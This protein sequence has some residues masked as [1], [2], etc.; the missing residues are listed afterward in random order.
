MIGITI[1][2]FG[3]FF[4]RNLI[5]G[6]EAEAKEIEKGINEALWDIEQSGY[7]NDIGPMAPE[8]LKQ[9][10]NERLSSII[11]GMVQFAQT[12]RPGGGG[13]TF[14]AW[15]RIGG[16]TSDF[17]YH[18]TRGYAIGT[19]LVK[20]DHSETDEKYKNEYERIYAIFN[21]SNKTIPDQALR[22]KI[23]D[24]SF[25]QYDTEIGFWVSFYNTNRNLG[26]SF[27]ESDTNIG[28]VGLGNLIKTMIKQESSFNPYDKNGN[29]KRHQINKSG[30]NDEIDGWGLMAVGKDKVN[31]LNNLFSL[32]F[33]A[34]S[35]GPSSTNNFTNIGVGI[36]HLC[37]QRY[38]NENGGYKDIEG[39]PSFINKGDNSLEAW[40]IA[41]KCYNGF[42]VEAHCYRDIVRER[43]RRYR[44]Q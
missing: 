38:Y 7:Y 41:V 8:L 11:K 43:Y 5:R 32:N 2:D 42:F 17:F 27:F 16:G 15:K 9:I 13:T 36:G 19:R 24:N 28:L 18:A 10:M 23:P 35:F 30:P 40:L 44:S 20:T 31:E 29:V 21:N 1:P 6:T 34:N 25:N 26:L 33:D 39:D 4:T 12:K 3:V 37:V 14:D 22:G